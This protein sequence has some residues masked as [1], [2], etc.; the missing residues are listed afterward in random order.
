MG[1]VA[2]WRTLSGPEAGLVVPVGTNVTALELGIVGAVTVAVVD[3]GGISMLFAPRSDGS[4]GG[5]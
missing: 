2:G 3:A 4:A 5:G 1:T